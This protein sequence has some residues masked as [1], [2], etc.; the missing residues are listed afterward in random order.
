MAKYIK[1]G[2]KAISFYDAFSRLKL[3]NQEQVVELTAK[4][5]KSPKVRRAIQTGHLTRSDEAG[6]EKYKAILNGEEPS[7]SSDDV[8]LDDLADKTKEELVK[9]YKV[10]YDVSEED[11]KAFS[12]LNKDIMLAELA[13]LEAEE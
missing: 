3:V 1:L 13:D 10:T 5:L 2:E 7:K 9:H 8:D 6:Y 12:K 11:V 4:Q